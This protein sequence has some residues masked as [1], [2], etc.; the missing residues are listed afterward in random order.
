MTTETKQE[1]PVTT[2]GKEIEKAV[3]TRALSPFDEMDRVFNRLM[4][5]GWMRPFGWERPLWRDF[6]EP[7]ELNLPRMDV[8]DR[9]GEILVRAEVPGVDKNDLEVSLADNMLTVKGSVS[10]KEKEEKGDYYRCETAQGA[11]VRTVAIPGKFDASK[12]AAS[13]KDGV[14]EIMLP[15]VEETK[16]H[17]IKV[18]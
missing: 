3:P 10:K 1:V 4:G 16:R 9:E 18:E 11:F 15:K 14:L 17:S 5:R 6:M 2:K 12:V 7:L 8:I 13:L